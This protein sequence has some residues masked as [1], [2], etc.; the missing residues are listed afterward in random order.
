MCR[1][2]NLEELVRRVGFN[3]VQ[4]RAIEVPTV[5]QTFEDYWEPFLGKVGPAPSYY[6]SLDERDRKRL[7]YRLRKTLPMGYDGSIALMAR[8]WAVQGTV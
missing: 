4:A 8:A 3:Q 6:M 2:G 5:F 1:E 7:E